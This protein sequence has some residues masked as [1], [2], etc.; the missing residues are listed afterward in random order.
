MLIHEKQFDIKYRMPYASFEKL[1]RILEA[2]LYL[3]SSKSLSSCGHPAVAPPV[4]LVLTICWLSGGSYRNV[5]DAGSISAPSFYRLLWLCLNAL[6][7]CD[8]LKMQLPTTHEQ[9]EPIYNG[10]ATKSTDSVIAGCVGALDGF[11]LLI[12]TPQG[13]MKLLT[14][15]RS[16]VVITSTWA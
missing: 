15:K 6:N 9:L 12:R 5:R 1:V 10:F 11:L 14:P 7:S 16:S 8:E 4:I 2:K 13:R 3:D